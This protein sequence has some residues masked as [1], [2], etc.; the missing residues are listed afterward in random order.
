MIIMYLNV[1]HVSSKIFE[2]E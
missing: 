1:H 2:K